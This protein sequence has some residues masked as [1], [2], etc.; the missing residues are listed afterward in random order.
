[1]DDRLKTSL[2]NNALIIYNSD[3]HKKT[4]LIHHATFETKAQARTAIFSFIEI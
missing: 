2:V 1:M 4:E 3:K